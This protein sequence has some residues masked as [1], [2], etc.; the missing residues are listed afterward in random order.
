M[1]AQCAYC[2]EVFVV[3]EDRLRDD[4]CPSCEAAE[5]GCSTFCLGK[6]HH[7]TTTSAEEHVASLGGSAYAY[8]CDQ[9]CPSEYDSD[10]ADGKGHHWH[11]AG[12]T[13]SRRMR[14]WVA[15]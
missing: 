10:G 1:T 7:A 2:D 8:E 4:L 15:S 3:D 11:V 14:K 6:I 5:E 9:L 13:V 12:S